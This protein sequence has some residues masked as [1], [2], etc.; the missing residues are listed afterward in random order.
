MSQ[1]ATY[2]IICRV[3]SSTQI[4]HVEVI[5][6]F[7][8]GIQINNTLDAP[9][10]PKG[11]NAAES[12]YYIIAKLVPANIHRKIFDKI[13]TMLMEAQ[14][15]CDTPTSD[16]EEIESLVDDILEKIFGGKH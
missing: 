1:L 4:A 6:N 12:F 3:P 7:T 16:D 11:S 9:L 10:G 5:L 13:G 2:E 14:K 8:D 15:E